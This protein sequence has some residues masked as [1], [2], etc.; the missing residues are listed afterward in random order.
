MNESS[1]GTIEQIREFLAGTSDVE[2]AV[3]SHGAV[4]RAFV[5][6][7]LE[8]RYLRRDSDLRYRRSSW[9]RFGPKAWRSPTRLS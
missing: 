6:R 1:L 7:I 9:I 5:Q 2:F 3:L 8:F 4:A